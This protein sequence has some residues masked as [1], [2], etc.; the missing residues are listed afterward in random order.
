MLNYSKGVSAMKVRLKF[1][2]NLKETSV[3]SGGAVGGFPV[4]DELNEMYSS[5]GGNGHI[6]LDGAEEV[7]AGAKERN[8]A[9]KNPNKSITEA[10]SFDDMDSIDRDFFANA[11]NSIEADPLA[12]LNDKEAAKKSLED[13][14][15]V[16][17][18]EL[19][20]GMWGTVYKGK[21]SFKQPCAIKVVFGH[22]ADRELSNYKT[23]S[24]AR[25][26]DELIAKHFPNVF[27]AWSPRDDIA[28]IAMELLEP[29]SAAQATF[30]PDASYLA[31]K[32]KAHRL[33]V[34][35]AS[36]SGMRDMSQRF[37][38]YIQNN[39]QE[40]S[41]MFDSEVYKFAMNYYNSWRGKITPEKLEDAKAEVSPDSLLQ[42]MQIGSS[43][44]RMSQQYFENRKASMQRV[45]GD[46]S[47]AVHFME[48]LQQEAPNALGANA[49]L[50]E[51]AFRIMLVG[52]MAQLNKSEIDAAIRSF[53]KS[54]LELARQ[55]TQIPMGY[56]VPDIN[57][58]QK[59]HERWFLTSR[60]LHSAIKALYDQTG[61][62]A[63]DLHDNN[64]MA[65]PNGDVVIV[66][67]G[68]FRQ[69]SG[70]QPKG[71]MQEMKRFRKKMLQN[72]QK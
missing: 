36:Y 6:S 27:E 45:L 72:L 58:P 23:I 35:A 18:E 64:V 11:E 42:I 25:E 47:D 17:G 4:D 52:L 60:G 37:T 49:A 12:G 32:N 51:I 39:I 7:F 50:A 55:F 48:I 34:A 1:K 2:K 66:D 28:V 21:N 24:A 41:A 9:N 16:V 69:D 43:A 68:L 33:A 26:A 46:G 63:K 67:V 8:A 29:L 19:G 71:Q 44:P 61:L 14:G 59:T 22:G 30:I 57:E 62:L 5:S 13:K 56:E 15:Y 20:Q 31:G 65:R 54:F 40:V 53:A 3:A 38:H 70:W 10:S